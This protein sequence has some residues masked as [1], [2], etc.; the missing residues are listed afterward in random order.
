MPSGRSLCHWVF[1]FTI[2][3]ALRWAK[4]NALELL[5]APLDV[6]S[7]WYRGWFF[8]PSVA[9]VCPFVHSSVRPDAYPSVCVSANLTCL[10]DNSKFAWHMD[11]WL[12]SAAIEY[13]GHGTCEGH[14]CLLL[15]IQ[16]N[17]ICRSSCL[18]R[19]G[20]LRDSGNQPAITYRS[21]LLVLP[22]P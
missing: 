1:T 3:S 7:T 13:V 22:I 16:K 10:Q 9:C 15:R 12:L 8:Y 18:V 4:T 19:S 6:I 11:H 17:G 14:L 20:A 2:A 21:G 5:Y